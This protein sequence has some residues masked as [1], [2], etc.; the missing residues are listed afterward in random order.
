[1]KEFD[2]V[3]E[4][5]DWELPMAPD[6]EDSYRVA[7]RQINQSSQSQSLMNSQMKKDESESG[8]THDNSTEIPPSSNISGAKDQHSP[9]QIIEVNHDVF[10]HLYVPHLPQNL[11]A[12]FV[13]R[14]NLKNCQ[15]CGLEFKIMSIYKNSHR[16]HC[17]R[18]G[19]SV[20]QNCCTSML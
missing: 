20:C 15:L 13:E 5:E 7:F 6:E 19:K 3:S 11:K 9:Q 1:M 18:C 4:L 17:R 14:Q 16:T 8:L 2:E 12:E 10:R